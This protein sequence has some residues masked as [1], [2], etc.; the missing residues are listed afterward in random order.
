[1]ANFDD[2]IR[3]VANLAADKKSF[4]SIY[5]TAHRDSVLA[6]TQDQKDELIKTYHEALNYYKQWEKEERESTINGI[7]NL[8]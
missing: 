2:L 3:E 8:I 1:M 6:C 7:N 4:D 5:N